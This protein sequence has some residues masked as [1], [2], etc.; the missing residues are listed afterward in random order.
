M[1]RQYWVHPILWDELIGGDE[2]EYDSVEFP[3][4]GIHMGLDIVLQFLWTN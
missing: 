2:R 1:Q 4:S 3:G